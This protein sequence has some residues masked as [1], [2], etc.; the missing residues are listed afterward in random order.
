MLSHSEIYFICSQKVNIYNANY[1]EQLENLKDNEPDITN[2]SYYAN[3]FVLYKTN[4]YTLYQE[5]V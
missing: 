4:I 5:D 3:S 1:Q 2:N